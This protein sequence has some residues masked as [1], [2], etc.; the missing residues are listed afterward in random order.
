MAT[1][2]EIARDSAHRAGDD[3]LASEGVSRARKDYSTKI[4]SDKDLRLGL[5][6]GK[7]V[8]PRKKVLCKSGS[9][10]TMET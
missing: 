8:R 2:H 7:S 6:G 4:S 5:W 1:L 3:F 9:E 10:T